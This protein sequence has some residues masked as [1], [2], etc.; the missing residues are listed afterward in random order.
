MEAI[1][2]LLPWTW[3]A[4]A[5]LIEKNF[6][7][8]ETLVYSVRIDAFSPPL[9][10]AGFVPGG[11]PGTGLPEGLR[12]ERPFCGI[13]NHIAERQLMAELGR[14]RSTDR[15]RPELQVA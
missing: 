1:E 11:R 15:S 8:G 10:S 3:V 14:L 9:R 6:N 7:R 13:V 12:S 5:T 4:I 2:A